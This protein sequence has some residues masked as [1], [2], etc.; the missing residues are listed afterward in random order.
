VAIAPNGIA[1]AAPNFGNQSVNNYAPLQRSLTQ[2][3]RNT[4]IAVL[5]KTC[6]FEVAVRAVP[7]NSESMSFGDELAKAI[8]DAGCTL[9]RPRFLIDTSAGY[10][11]WVMLHDRDNI[12]TGADALVDA[13]TQ[14]GLTPKTNTLDAIEPGVVY[15][16]VEFNDAK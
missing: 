14:A 13:L 10:G 5:R 3:Q 2:G 8:T 4:F 12:P 16:M 11:V 1:N 15:L 7:G 6:P 9:R